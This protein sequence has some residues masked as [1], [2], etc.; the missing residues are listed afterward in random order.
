MAKPGLRCCVNEF[1]TVSKLQVGSLL[2]PL[3]LDALNEFAKILV[4][5]GKSKG[6][7]FSIDDNKSFPNQRKQRAPDC[8]NVLPMHCLDVVA[9]DFSGDL[10]QTVFADENASASDALE[11][12][13]AEHRSSENR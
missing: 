6:F 3:L 8:H 11:I 4:A 13:L 7:P 12:H 5:V 10:E 2:F 1:F 9:P